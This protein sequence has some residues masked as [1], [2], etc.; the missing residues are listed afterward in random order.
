LSFVAAIDCAS[1]TAVPLDITLPRT[2]V[3]LFFYF[4]GQYG[5][6]AATVGF[7]DPATL[8]G[9]RACCTSR[10]ARWHLP[11]VPGRT[12]LVQIDSDARACRFSRRGHYRLAGGCVKDAVAVAAR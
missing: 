12:L 6:Y 1:L 10:P 2:G 5:N 3:L 11:G 7:W 8:A 9:A 4:D